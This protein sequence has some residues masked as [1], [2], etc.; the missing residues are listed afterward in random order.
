M[1]HA[2]RIAIARSRALYAQPEGVTCKLCGRS[3][4]L[5]R[6]CWIHASGDGEALDVRTCRRDECGWLA[7]MALESEAARRYLRKRLS[8]DE[9]IVWTKKLRRKLARMYLLDGK[10]R[11]KEIRT[12]LRA[13]L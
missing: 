4:R 6:E 3:I 2:V 1:K 8:S 7:F 11:L 9:R 5:G 12:M 10:L 13:Q